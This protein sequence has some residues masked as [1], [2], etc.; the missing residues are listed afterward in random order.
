MTEERTFPSVPA[1]VPQARRYTLQA[2]TGVAADLADAIAVMVSELTTN[3]VRH[4]ATDFTV[5]IDQQPHEIRVAVTDAG[6]QQPTLRS[7]GPTEPSGRGLRIVSALADGWGVTEMVDRPGKTVWF[8]IAVPP[9]N[10]RERDT[11]ADRIAVVTPEGDADTSP[12]SAP[13]RKRTDR[14]EQASTA[15]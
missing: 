1:S 3:S 13:E 5:S 8:S 15:S 2:L 14:R 11:V 4:A 7:P 9:V 10:A 12:R 6:E